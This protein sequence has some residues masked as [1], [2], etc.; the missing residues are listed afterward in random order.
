MPHVLS[1]LALAIGLGVGSAAVAQPVHGLAM[2]GAPKHP[3]GFRSF[4]YVDP[5]APRGGRLTQGMLGTFDS[6]NPFIIRGVS[7]TGLREYVFESLMARSADEPFTL[8]GLIAESV[9]LP[10]D[11]AWVTFHL[12]PEARFADGLPITPDDVL[13]SHAILKEKGWPYHRSHYGKVAKAEKIGERSVRFTFESAGDREVPL[14]LALMPILPRHRL[15]AEAF[16]RTTLEPPLG[17]G[18]YSVARVDAGRSITYRRNDNWWARDLAVMRGRFNFDEI[19][20][21]YFRD[22]STMFE[23][24]KAG[25]LDIRLEDDPGRWVEGYDFAAVTDGRIIKREF[26]TGLPSGMSGLVFNTRR[27]AFQDPRVRRAFNLLFDAEWMNRNLFNG[28]FKR[29]QSYFERSY[30]SSHGRRA[31]ARERALLAPFADFVKPE[32]LE[33]TYRQPV[34]EDSRANLKAAHKLLLEAGYEIKGGRMMKAGRRLSVEFLAQ[35][36]AQERLLLSYARTLDKLGIALSVRH[37]DSA[38]YNVRLKGF[39]FDMVQWNW[40]ASLSPGNEQINRWSSKA[41]DIEGSL[42]LAG[43]KNPAADAMIEAMLQADSEEDFTAAVRAFD[44][45][46]ISGD[47]AIPLFYLPKVWVAYRSHLKFPSTLPLGGFDADTWWSERR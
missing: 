34:T 35:T 6:L 25:D 45:V 18:P 15:D 2:H 13:F 33:G 20:V 8:Y 29:T 23:A 3:A 40:T 42:N 17:S 30:L 39:D 14:L 1:L 22:A 41:A 9:E 10:P 32:V 43:V 26:D 16:E 5:D 7:A 21:E 36:R 12:R 4:P 11:R 46:L 44:R 38:Q 28:L 27:P 19:R 24:F 47:Y 31:D 37:V